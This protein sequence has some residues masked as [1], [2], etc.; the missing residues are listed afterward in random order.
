MGEVASIGRVA[1]V[2][3]VLGVWGEVSAWYEERGVG[4][5]DGL[6]HG[7][8]HRVFFR[9]SGKKNSLSIITLFKYICVFKYEI[10][11]KFVGAR[12]S[13]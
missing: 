7:Q 9:R 11:V 1:L 13:V 5:A 6:Q 10:W 3:W 4:V 2:R 12:N 8:T